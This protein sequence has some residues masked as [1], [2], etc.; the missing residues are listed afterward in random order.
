[1]IFLP[2]IFGIDYFQFLLYDLK[3]TLAKGYHLRHLNAKKFL[4]PAQ[5]AR[6]FSLTCDNL[7][8]RMRYYQG[9]IDLDKLKLQSF[10]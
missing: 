8:K 1:M 3:T 2:R 7:G 6:A 10:S 4:K 9:L 5:I